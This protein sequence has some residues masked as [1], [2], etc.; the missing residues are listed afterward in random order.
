[1]RSHQHSPPHQEAQPLLRELWD[2]RAWRLFPLLLVYMS[3]LT[4]LVPHVPGIMT[5]YFAERRAGH[6]LHCDG[7]PSD[8][9]APDAAACR[10]AHADVVLW[11]SWTSFFSNSLVSIVLTPLLGHWSDLHGRK[12]FFLACS[13]IPLA[14]VLLHL[15]SGLPLLWYYVVQVFISSL[16]SV[17]VSLA[18]I[19]DLLCRA[20]RAAT[21]GLIM[22]IFSVAIFIGP[23]A[24][25]AMAPVTAALAS[26]GT[27]GACAAY[28]LLILPESLSP[29][30]KAAA[31]LCH[32]QHRH[33]DAAPGAPGSPGGSSGGGGGGG[34]VV[35]L[36]TL[37][38]ARILL[39]SPLFKRL[40]LCMMLTGVV[41]EGLQDL[42]VQY[43]K[44]KMEFGVADVS[45][46]FMI[47]GACGLLVQTLLLRTLLNW[48]GEQRV[49]LVALAASAVQ[50]VIL[51]AAGVKWVAFLGIGLGSLGSMS[52]PTISSIK[53]NNAQASRGAPFV[54]GLV[55]M[56]LAIAVA[57][58]IPSTAGGSGGSIERQAAMP[59]GSSQGGGSDRESLLRKGVDGVAAAEAPWPAGE[60]AGAAAAA[61]G[62]SR[63]RSGDLE[64]GGG[65]AAAEQSRIEKKS[66]KH[67][68]QHDSSSG[69]GG[70]S[71]DEG[72]K[73]GGG[74]RRRGRGQ[75][76]DDPS[77][78]SDSDGEGGLASGAQREDWMT[79]PMQRPKTDAQLAAEEEEQ[80]RQEEEE[81]R[82]D[83]DRPFVSEREL[84]PYFK[85]GGSGVPGEGA[86][87]GAPPVRPAAGI[88]DGGASWR[89]KALK[90][91]QQQ[92]EQEGKKLNE[93]VSER[94]G[95]LAELTGGLTA[96][97]RA[98]HGM[99]HLH[100]AR[101][102]RATDP[103]FGAR[104]AERRRMRE[105]EEGGGGGEG[106]KGGKGR[107]GDKAAYLSE[108][109]SVRSQ[110]QRPREAGSLSWR[111][112]S[113]CGERRQEGG[114]PGARRDGG[115]RGG[116]DGDRRREGER[117]GD[118]GDRGGGGDRDRRREDEA[119]E[120]RRD[121][122]QH[123]GDR[124]RDDR[125]ARGR[126]E[127]EGRRRPARDPLGRHEDAAVLKA[128]AAELNQFQ[129]D[130]SFMDQF[131]AMQQ[132]QQG[133]R[134]GG[135]ERPGAGAEVQ[136]SASSGSDSE[137]AREAQRRQERPSAAAAMAAERA[138]LAARPAAAA[139]GPAAEAGGGD[140]GEQ[141]PAARSGGGGGANNL[142]VAAMLRARL[143]GK[144]PPPEAQ[145]PP[146]RETV[147]LPQ[148]DARGRAVPGAFGREEAGTGLLDGGRKQK[149]V[150]RY[151]G[152]ERSKYFADD[153]DTDLQTLMKR[154]KHGDEGDIDARLAAG[155]TRSQRYK[156]ADYDPDA[157]Y[158]HDAGLEMLDKRAGK[159][160]REG[161]QQRDKQRQI[162]EYNRM[163]SALEKCRLCFSSASRPRHLAVAIG[164]SSYLALP[165]RGRLVP[166]HC[167]IVPA[168]HV[169]S[170]RQVD[171]QVWSELRNFKKCLIQMFMKQASGQEVV[172]F[173]T[174]LHLGSMRSHA[175]VECVPV[176]P[177]VAGRA[178]MFFKKA[179]DDATSEWAQHHA[180]RFI[181]TKA[182]GLRG[183]V[184]PNFPYL[185]VEFGISDGF[186]HVVDD[187]EKFDPGLARSVMIGLLS[188]P[189]ED[190][191]R[192]ARQENP[193][194][195]QQWAEEFRK[196]FEPY[197]WTRMLE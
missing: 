124:P 72:G 140:G 146:E 193:S 17:T 175:V 31:R 126:E 115:D 145:A 59:G 106:G 149:R 110:M 159:K 125:P 152:G 96:G 185:N 190:M 162:R 62:G 45:H 50:Q 128:A 182:K 15:T 52:F 111:R 113:E 98:A 194:I 63:R 49:L 87:A 188:L 97:R 7:L 166:G 116:G 75:P 114:P 70:G 41:S 47:F 84:N 118:R 169:A 183:S 160:G 189:Q 35:A 143:T 36:S 92:A 101:D 57:A 24:G 150:Q 178:P 77:S 138:S 30:A 54:F 39:R 10:D 120:R 151:E 171:E 119:G 67:K 86:A 64:G 91:A 53:S 100:S 117:R 196:Q 105:G 56:L 184:P 154:T 179:V 28:T 20:N 76:W 29:G 192:R 6:T 156:Q 46:I 141:R 2:T 164:Q 16:S 147:V 58:T 102:R 37:R 88:G 38:A 11:S 109:K 157:E 165:A 32:A 26:L 161:Q 139:A 121:R 130:G 71:S 44:L 163:N 155:I 90:R 107:E 135:E 18:Y 80:E 23:A 142:S 129:A 68:K 108:M 14:I 132:Q 82:R 177:A 158:D 104:Q 5:D 69:G 21:F 197:D 74:G 79:K 122:E 42:L 73:L 99:A 61:R 25:A 8:A 55:L 134:E 43:L 27:V 19:A 136:P 60:E 81:Q 89:L 168:E 187:E 66:S 112:G 144:A 51:A 1:M 40:T 13:C 137:E 48:L 174:A 180:K 95:S 170:T 191:H 173:E 123:R 34:G 78:G 33:Q 65:S 176:P 186:V 167:V 172:F 127:A 195:Q 3:G 133:G 12:L 83:P 4:L 131:Q 148:V 85:D 22:A 103:E 9:A 153:D 94:F 181:D 93:V